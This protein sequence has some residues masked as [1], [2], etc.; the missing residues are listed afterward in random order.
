M[1]PTKQLPTKAPEARVTICY[2]STVYDA[3]TDAYTVSVIVTASGLAGQNSTVILQPATAE[4]EPSGSSSLNATQ[5]NLP[6][7]SVVVSLI[8]SGS[9]VP[10]ALTAP[11]PRFYVMLETDERRI[12]TEEFTFLP[13][14]TPPPVSP[15]AATVI[16]PA[17]HEDAESLGAV[18]ASNNVYP[19]KTVK[20]KKTGKDKIV[21]CGPGFVYFGGQAMAGYRGWAALVKSGRA[22]AEEQLAISIM[23]VNEGN[24]DAVNAY[25]NQIITLGAMQKTITPTGQGELCQQLFEF[26]RANPDVYERLLGRYGWTIITA[27]D[28]KNNT[29]R[30]VV[31]IDPVTKKQYA[32]KELYDK[33]RAG[34]TLATVGKKKQTNLMLAPFVRLGQNALFQDKQ[35]SDFITRMNTVLKQKPEGSTH[36]IKEYFTQPIGWAVAL[37]QSVNRPGHVTHYLKIAIER[38]IAA[39]PEV[40]V[41]PTKWSIADRPKFE[42]WLLEIYGPIRA[43]KFPA[44]PRPSRVTYLGMTDALGRYNRIKKAFKAKG[45]VF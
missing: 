44:P 26:K 17:G 12:A 40:D 37:D 8:V 18:F 6:D 33:V 36:T 45:Y 13:G 16:I 11:L 32:D 27:T 10:N 34:S 23:S 39:H 15:P 25:D 30:K 31:F 29:Y 43:E 20:D 4:P 35:V 21:G 42:K 3:K 28:K 1:D 14:T 41:D 2:D 22:S 9:V 5:L 19:K 38:L 7:G 24:F